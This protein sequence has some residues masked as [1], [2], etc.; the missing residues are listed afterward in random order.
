[1]AMTIGRARRLIVAIGGVVILT[2]GM[3]A[4]ARADGCSAAGKFKFNA[5]A[6]S[7][8]LFLSA[9]GTVEMDLVRG[10][11]LCLVCGGGG[12]ILRGTYFTA[13]LDQGCYFQMQL[14]PFPFTGNGDTLV[15]MVAFE[16]RQLVFAASTSPDFAS[17]LALRYDA[18][19]GR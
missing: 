18:L 6:G 14:S 13:I 4:A 16:G 1:M 15:G 7:G 12:V 2:L 5:A 17:G 8:F 19:T 9:D 10:H 3:A 11:N